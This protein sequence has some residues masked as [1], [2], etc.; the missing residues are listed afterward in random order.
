MLAFAFTADIL[1]SRTGNFG[2]LGFPPYGKSTFQNLDASCQSG[3]G[4]HPGRDVTLP[5]LFNF[6]SVRASQ[7]HN[8]VALRQCNRLFAQLGCGGTK[9][10]RHK[11]YLR[12]SKARAHGAI[13]STNFASY[14]YHATGRI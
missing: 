12:R 13:K 4:G 10:P 7:T 9:W 5:L 3:E 1:A 11:R 2:R 8:K 6:I 14:T